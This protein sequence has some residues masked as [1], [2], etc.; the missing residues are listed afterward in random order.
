MNHE[1]SWDLVGA[2]TNKLY[3]RGGRITVEAADPAPR[4]DLSGCLILPG[5]INAHDHLEFA[6]F[7][8]LGH[9]PYPNARAW[10]EAVYHPAESPIREHLAVPKLD[11]LWWGGLK[12]LLSGVATVVQHNPFEEIAHDPKFPVRLAPADWAHSLDFSPDL[13]ERFRRSDARR[14][15]ILHAAEGTDQSAADEVRRLDELG[16]LSNRTALVHAVGVDADGWRRVERTATAIIACP[17]S[18]LFTLGR[19]LEPARLGQ[20]D[21]PAQAACTAQAAILGTDS[22]LTAAGD[23]FDELAAAVEIGVSP[24][25]ALAMVTSRAAKVL[26]LSEGSGTLNPGA[27]ADLIVLRDRGLSPAEALLGRPRENLLMVMLGGQVR[28]LADGFDPGCAAGALAPIVY[29]GRRYRVAAP[30]AELLGRAR[31]A[32]GPNVR[33]A[34]KQVTAS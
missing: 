30:V 8:R 17:T 23:L 29:G 21:G 33:L 7:P 15:F 26:R 5:L 28:L 16:V 22:P 2:S 18:N 24:S 3:V 11:R 32:L 12:N 4:L 34:G 20:A 14:P 31:A 19:T 9:G 10:A 27:P 13:L 1:P 6:L 25:T